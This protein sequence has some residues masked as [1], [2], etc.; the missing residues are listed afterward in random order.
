MY[1]RRGDTMSTI[2]TDMN[3]R[4]HFEAVFRKMGPGYASTIYGL[5]PRHQLPI[6]AVQTTPPEPAP[7][8]HRHVVDTWA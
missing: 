4:Q 2:K 3:A 8:G 6:N 7:A 1:G 5:S